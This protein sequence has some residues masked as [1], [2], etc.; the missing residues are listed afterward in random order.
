MKLL[1]KLLSQPLLVLLL[2]VA[3]FMVGYHHVA[4][5]VTKFFLQKEQFESYKECLKRTGDEYICK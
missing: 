3:L 2:V 5:P 1:K 4:P